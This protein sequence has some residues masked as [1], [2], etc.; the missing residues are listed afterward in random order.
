MRKIR[1][2]IATTLL[3][4]VSG[5]A[6]A[7]AVTWEFNNAFFSDGGELTGTFDFNADSPGAA[8]FSKIN[9]ETSDGFLPG[10]MTGAEYSGPALPGSNDVFLWT[11]AD[12]AL[13]VLG[14]TL[15]EAM[16]N[17][18]A[19]AVIDIAPVF[20]SGELGLIPFSV[21]V[22]TT[23]YIESIAS[24]GGPGGGTVQLAEPAILAI[25]VI[26]LMAVGGLHLR[27]RAKI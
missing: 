24:L 23:G 27:R 25:F 11:F 20:I 6:H 19:G 17:T 2:L 21:R 18:N 15:T 14:V 7:W 5:S 9:L 16:T 26:G 4:L 3:L 10:A 22:I 13:Q 1:F 8:G 12:N